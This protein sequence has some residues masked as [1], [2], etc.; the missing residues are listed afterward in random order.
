MAAQNPIIIRFNLKDTPNSNFVSN[1]ESKYSLTYELKR[2][3][4]SN[5]DDFEN[6]SRH[7]SRLLC[8]C[9][10]LDIA[11]YQQQLMYRARL[12]G[13][14][15]HFIFL[16]RLRRDEC[17]VSQTRLCFHRVITTCQEKQRYMIHC[18]LWR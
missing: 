9:Q 14:T 4:L 2:S 11:R 7:F 5:T 15:P 16:P 12:S 17:R 1:S 3:Y 10:Y 13:L 18:I 8:I 6:R